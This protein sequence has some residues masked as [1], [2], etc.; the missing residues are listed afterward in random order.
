MADNAALYGFRW[1]GNRKGVSQPKPQRVY[2][3][4]GYQAS[5]GGVSVDLN[6]GDPVKKVSDGTVALCAAGDATYGII[7]GVDPYW[8]GAKFARSNRLPGGTAW[9]TVQERK[10]KLLILPVA[11]QYFEC[12]CDDATTF[13]TE[14]TYG[15]AVG[16]NVDMTINQVSGSTLAT[17][18]LDISTHGTSNALVWRIVD[19]AQRVNTDYSG[20]NVPLIVTCNLVQEAPFQT[21]GV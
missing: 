4:T 10:S 8:D 17:P 11:E 15:A 21:T 12:V 18:K 20:A 14:A 19:Y 9:G 16:E 6:V 5:P 7:I 3:A 1:V 2:V 13:T